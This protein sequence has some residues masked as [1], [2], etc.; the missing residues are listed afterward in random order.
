MLKELLRFGLANKYFEIKRIG[1]FTNSKNEGI[2]HINTKAIDFDE[3][4]KNLCD[5]QGQELCKSC[6]ALDIVDLKNKINL[7]E[8][9]Q[10]IDNKDI[11]KWIHNLELPQKIK[12]S[13][14]VLLNIIRKD[15]FNHGGKVKKFYSCE[16]NVIIAFDLTDHTKKRMAILFRYPIV[17]AIIEKQFDENYIQGENFNDPICIRMDNFDTEYSKYA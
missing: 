7:I 6:D 17:E 9:K 13:R 5:E 3:T 16:K 14:G 11:E 8:F 2:S 12:D 1:D 4:T 15:T 10:L